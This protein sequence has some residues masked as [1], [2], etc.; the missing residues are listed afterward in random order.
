MD[1]VRLRRWDDLAKVKGQETPE[2][3]HFVAIMRAC[4]YTPALA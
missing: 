1:A 4:V 3:E 2:L